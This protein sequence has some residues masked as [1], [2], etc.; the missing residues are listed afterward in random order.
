MAIVVFD[1]VQGIDVFG[2]ADVFYFA[3]YVVGTTGEPVAP[4]SVEL[5]ALDS[6]V[7]RTA[8]GPS[9]V[10]DRSIDD[11]ALR[12]DVLLVAG[13]LDVLPL[14]EDESFVRALSELASRSDEV[15][16]VCTGALL[17]AESGLLDGRTATTHWAL[18]EHLVRRHPTVAVDAD[19]IFSFDGVWSSAG[20]TAGI[21][22][23]LQLVRSHHGSEV[24][25]GV[26][27][28]MVVYL[29]RAGGQ[30]Q[31]ST[32]LAAQ[33]SEHPTISDVMAFVADHPDAD[34]SVGALA[35]RLHMSE[36]SFHR[37]FV[38]EVGI[39]PGRYVEHARI[40]AARR[41]LERTDHGLSEIARG[42]GFRSPE[43]FARCFRR[44]VGIN[45]TEY[46]SKFRLR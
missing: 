33:R 17:L 16:S 30:Q 13:G 37:L 46:R 36:R 21:D 38:A 10:A 41:A 5:V 40:D 15:G 32:H 18:A 22:M 34:L 25:S 29:E 43:T 4:Y 39:S 35:D 7:V 19:R 1:G 28:N 45:P 12:P 3:N 31:F 8:A 20:V 26:A 11:P 9:L 42:C 2:P 24:A 27:R 14:A 23:A 44:V 6:G